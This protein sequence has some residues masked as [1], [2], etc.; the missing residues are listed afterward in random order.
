M[1]PTV[2]YTYTDSPLL[3]T[4]FDGSADAAAVADRMQTLYGV[5]RKILNTTVPYSDTLDLNAQVSLSWFGSSYS[6]AV[7]GLSDVFDGAY[8]KQKITVIA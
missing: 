3:V 2:E 5:P 8:P 7:V 1:T 6:G 4:Y